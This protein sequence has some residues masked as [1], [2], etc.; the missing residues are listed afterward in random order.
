LT[1]MPECNPFQH[2]CQADFSHLDVVRTKFASNH[3]RHIRRQRFLGQ[4]HTLLVLL[5]FFYRFHTN[6]SLI[7]LSI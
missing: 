5:A 3:Q 2:T 6:F 7:Q 1:Q 4:S